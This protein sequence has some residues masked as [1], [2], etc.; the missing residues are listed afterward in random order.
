LATH[1][2]SERQNKAFVYHD[3]LDRLILA[4]Y[5]GGEA[6]ISSL[7]ANSFAGAVDWGSGLLFARSRIAKNE[8]E[9]RLLRLVFARLFQY[10]H[11]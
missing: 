10:G 2:H 6:G 8:I 5:P 1:K 4:F 3:I 11:S 7:L 9:I